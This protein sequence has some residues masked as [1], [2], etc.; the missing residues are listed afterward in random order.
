MPFG[1]TLF[2]PAHRDGP[3]LRLGGRLQR[4]C[5]RTMGA[6]AWPLPPEGDEGAPVLPTGQVRVAVCGAHLSGLPLNGQLTS[7]GGRLVAA[8]RS[9]PDYK[10]YALPG[11][12]PKRPGMVRVAEGGAAIDMEVWELPAR[13][14]GSFVA[15]IPG[16]LGIGTVKLDD[17]SSVQGFVCEAI[18]AAGAEDITALGSWRRYL[19]AQRG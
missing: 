18:A 2:A 5:V 6:R 7:R 19:A 14:F 12:P 13:E 3:L 11:G 16:P 9:A 10:F 15:G 17:G 8:V 1:V 4:A